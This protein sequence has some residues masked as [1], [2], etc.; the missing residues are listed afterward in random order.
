MEIV[1]NIYPCNLCYHFRM[2]IRPRQAMGL[3]A[4]AIAVVM[5]CAFLFYVAMLTVIDIFHDEPVER[6]SAVEETSGNVYAYDLV[7][8][9]IYEDAYAKLDEVS[10]VSAASAVTAHHLLV[11][12]EIAFLFETI[13]SDDVRTV[14]L[15]SPNH[16]D[17]G[18]SVFQTSVGSW[19]GPFGQISADS[20]LVERLA[21]NI[22]VL[23]I[24]E[25]TFETEHGISAVAPFVKKSFPNAGLIPL[26]VHDNA[27]VVEIQGLA[28]AITR[29]APNAVV[30]ASVDMSHYQP[31]AAQVFHDDVT[32][33]TLLNS[34][35]GLDS[36]LDLETDSHAALNLLYAI[37]ALRKTQAWTQTSHTASLSGGAVLQSGENTSHL[38]GYYSDGVVSPRPFAALHVVGDI[39][40]DRGVRKKTNE[41]GVAYP[42]E[43]MERFLRG[44][45][46][47]IGNLE[48]TVNEQASTYT[49]NPPFRFV[50]S[51]DSVLEM[52]KYVDVVSLANNHASDVGSAGQEETKD[53][54]D[55]MGIEWFGSYATPVPRYD[56]DING[57]KL[58]YIGY[59]QF[60]PAVEELKRE[61]AAA[62]DDG[63]FV[64]VFP[65][66]GNEYIKSPQ[67]NQRALAQI[68]VDAGADLIIG[69][70]PHVAQGIEVLGD[71]PIVYSLGNFIFDQQI[72]ETWPAFTLGVIVESETITL[73]LLPVTTR[74][75]KPVPMEDE[76]AEAFF[77]SIAALSTANL[78][79]QITQGVL[80]LPYENQ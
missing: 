44:T 57:M 13:G 68:M 62:S 47:V 59:H 5:Y 56:D 28:S 23:E 71:V 61:I 63:R 65:H 29:V 72:P 14:V 60:Q 79:S 70:H 38:M 6:A 36:D 39:M 7:S 50:F 15:I 46:T 35:F 32:A 26:V 67:A 12:E 16:F 53:R 11:S 37:N 22:D 45:H 51:P 55:D 8:S 69:G 75:G 41:F 73:H 25:S 76:A 31:T 33:R 77:A 48:G 78:Q 34:S 49:Y 30:I 74:D 18:R 4:V 66:W 40:L 9:S 19:D 54:L 64:I 42:W 2:K 1:F 10:R 52:S 3:C 43:H 27:S 58:T 21:D 80:T 17:E 20:K 24:E